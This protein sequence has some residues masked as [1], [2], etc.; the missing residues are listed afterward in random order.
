[1]YVLINEV[2]RQAQRPKMYFPEMETQ[3]VPNNLII[4]SSESWDDNEI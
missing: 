2:T 4:E 3:S 1:M